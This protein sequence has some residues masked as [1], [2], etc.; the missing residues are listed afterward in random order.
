MPN[1]TKS[2]QTRLGICLHAYVLQQF[3][4]AG[5]SIG[6]SRERLH[7]GVHEARKAI[8]RVRAA[9]DL[10]RA[11][12]WPDAA[13]V[14]DELRDLC[15][16]LSQVRD[17]YAVIETLD[18]LRK[19]APDAD[20]R[21]LL[22]RVRKSLIERHAKAASYLLMQDAG[23]RRFR[24][25]L[26][27]LRELAEALS[28]SEIDATNIRASLARSD[29]R[30]ERAAHAAKKT[31]HGRLRHRW[32]R[33][34][35]RL[36]HQMMILELALSWRFVEDATSTGHGDESTSEWKAFV[37]VSATMLGHTTDL[38]GHE[39]D[40]RMLRA[41]ARSTRGIKAGDRTEILKILRQKI[42]ATPKWPSR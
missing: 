3:D 13:V 40:L 8:R 15:R 25:R 24:A 26:H 34:L 33:R 42:D 19:Q 31:Q 29:H 6:C 14:F 36:R 32:R 41:A 7:T 39:H 38:L 21:D 4:V 5:R 17:A 22:K 23:L 20:Q 11:R 28:W 16:G 9:L 35:R 12:L 37:R 1:A 30:A 18:H 10:G 2:T 27:H